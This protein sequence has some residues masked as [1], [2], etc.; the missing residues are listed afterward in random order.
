MALPKAA[1]PVNIQS[2]SAVS[3]IFPVNSNIFNDDEFMASAVADRAFVP[4]VSPVPTD[5]ASTV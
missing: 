5:T 3:G 1:T 4:P 2:G